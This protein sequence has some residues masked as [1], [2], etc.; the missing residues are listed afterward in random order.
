MLTSAIPA[1]KRAC[2]C[3]PRFSC[4]SVCRTPVRPG[5]LGL[6]APKVRKT[7]TISHP[8]ERETHGPVVVSSIGTLLACAGLLQVGLHNVDQLLRRLGLLRGRVVVRVHQ[9][10]ADMPLKE[11]GHQTVECPPTS[12]NRH[13][14]RRTVLLLNQ[15]MLDG[16]KLPSNAVYPVQQLRLVSDGMGHRCS[17]GSRQKFLGLYHTPI[18]YMERGSGTSA[19]LEIDRLFLSSPFWINRARHSRRRMVKDSTRVE[20]CLTK[21]SD[22]VGEL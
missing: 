16:V 8:G 22:T 15:R 13:Q 4:T 7:C 9:V 12:G 1:T 17:F 5:P 19:G 2:D 6:R 10:K 20:D 14:N 21:G 18:G 11:F 3:Q